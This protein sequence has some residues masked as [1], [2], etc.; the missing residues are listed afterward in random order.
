MAKKI[1]SGFVPFYREG[2]EIL[3]FGKTLAVAPASTDRNGGNG[4]FNSMTRV[5]SFTERISLIES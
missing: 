1:K 4:K 3:F 5:L 2:S